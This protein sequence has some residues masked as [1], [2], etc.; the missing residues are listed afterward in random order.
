MISPT[1]NSVVLLVLTVS[2]V[3]RKESISLLTC[4]LV[5]GVQEQLV[6]LPA[7]IMIN[8]KD[9]LDNCKRYS[10]FSS[11]LILFVLV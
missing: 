6:L 2:A 7:L 8:S 1:R 5:D 10:L 9:C 11:N 3:C 4:S